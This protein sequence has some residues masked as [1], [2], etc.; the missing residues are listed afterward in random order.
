MPLLT[1]LTQKAG[2]D[3]RISGGA[4]VEVSGLTSDSR[5]VKPGMLFAAIKGTAVDGETF[6]PDAIE[7]GAVAVLVESEK[8][9]E[10]VAT[11]HVGNIRHSLA[12]IAASFYDQQPVHTVAI[13]GTNGKTSTAEF[14]RQIWQSAGQKSASIGTLGL[15]SNDALRD[16]KY[17]SSN[18]SPDPIV[19]S[20]MLS[21]LTEN[22][23]QYVAIE[24]SSHGLDQCRLDGV[25]LEAAAFTN[26]S[27]DHLDYHGSMDEYFAAK[28]RLFSD[29]DLSSSKVVV[30]AD[31]VRAAD[32]AAVCSRAGWD[33]LS[34]GRAGEY[35]AL[36][37]A[38]PVAD[39]LALS[40]VFDGELFERSVPVY[41]QFQAMNLCA[42]SGLAVCAGMAV[43][44]LFDVLPQ[45]SGVRGRMERVGVHPCGA[46]VFVD[47]AHTPDALQNVLAGLREHAENKLHVVFGC[48][49]DR[50]KGKRSQMGEVAKRYADVVVV[51]DDNPRSECPAAIRKNILVTV[52]DAKEI[53]DRHEAITHAVNA[54][55]KGDV[56]VIAGKGHETYQIVGEQ[57]LYFD[58]SEVIKE[59]LG[60]L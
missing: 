29:F 17:P 21:E 43:E 1:R 6:I 24:A 54:L 58:D 49:G 56:L 3:A 40:A 2:I 19:L 15:C 30:N 4:E 59:A 36:S 37:G 52:S 20:E 5:K 7:K 46:P 55:E 57:T 16:G 12:K 13:T 27:R 60:S 8:K 32:V 10:S 31:D 39:G 47:Y 53:G 26:F 9:I 51:T 25:R 48:G 42:A 35:I 33:V 18:T 50:D 14:Y 45:L 28:M 38:R 11:I 41:G 44:R 22:D 34:Y 23:I